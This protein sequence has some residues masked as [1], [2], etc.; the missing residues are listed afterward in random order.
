MNNSLICD[1][2]DFTAIR[3]NATELKLKSN[4]LYQFDCSEKKLHIQQLRNMLNQEQAEILNMI[5]ATTIP[6]V[7][8]QERNAYLSGLSDGLKLIAILS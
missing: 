4:E 1:F 3:L 8:A 2:E 5:E 7:G 6:I